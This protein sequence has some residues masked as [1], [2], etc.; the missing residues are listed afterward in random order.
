MFYWGW[1]RV[2]FVMGENGFGKSTI[3]ES[4]AIFLGIIA[5]WDVQK[6]CRN[7]YFIIKYFPLN[8]R[9]TLLPLCKN[10]TSWKWYPIFFV[11]IGEVPGKAV[12]Y[13]GLRATA[14]I[15][16]LTAIIVE[17]FSLKKTIYKKAIEI[18]IAMIKIDFNVIV[19]LNF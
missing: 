19:Y 13:V 16:F 11:Q 15:C 14:P 12:A 17:W 6:K 4:L 10:Q 2:T 7:I 9:F 18:S 8:I 1:V 5:F 3:I